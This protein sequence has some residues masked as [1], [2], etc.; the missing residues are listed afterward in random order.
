M[1][2]NA[3]RILLGRLCCVGY[4]LPAGTILCFLWIRFGFIP[5]F[6]CFPCVVRGPELTLNLQWLLFF[7]IT[8]KCKP[9]IYGDL[10]GNVCSA[11]FDRKLT[12]IYQ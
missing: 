5:I 4:Y 11:L 1:D 2:I 10:L 12:I 8:V 9:K 7:C 6:L 3:T